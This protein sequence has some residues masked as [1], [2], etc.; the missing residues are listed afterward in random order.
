VKYGLLVGLNVRSRKGNAS[1]AMQRLLLDKGEISE[2]TQRSILQKNGMRPNGFAR[3]TADFRFTKDEFSNQSWNIGMHA[4]KNL[5]HLGLSTLQDREMTIMKAIVKGSE[6]LL[7]R[8]I[9]WPITIVFS[10]SNPGHCC[11]CSIPS[12]VHVLSPSP[13][14]ACTS[15]DIVV[16]EWTQPLPREWASSQCATTLKL[17]LDVKMT[18]KYLRT[19]KSA[20]TIRR[21]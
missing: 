18:I 13:T 16:A 21:I 20:V 3:S 9:E 4:L 12:E 11:S 5:D 19:E 2:S 17:Y 10:V 15:I 1:R 14:S 8:I 7:K 6:A